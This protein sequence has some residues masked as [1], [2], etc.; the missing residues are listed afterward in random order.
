M[1]YLKNHSRLALGYFL[2]AAL[3]GLIL[4]SFYVLEI[5]ITFK[6]VVHAHSHIALL[7]WVYIALTTIIYKLYLEKL[8]LQKKY[9]YIFWFTQLTLV[10]MLCSFPFQGYAL[11]SIVFSTLFLIASY[12]FFIF[13]KKHISSENKEQNSYY[14]INTALWY[15]VISSIGPWALGGIMTTLGATS[16]WYRLAIYF[17]LHFQYNGWMILAL[18]GILL[19]I[20]EEQNIQVSKAVFKRFF[21]SI[22][23]GIITTFFLSTLF[24]KPPI[25]LYIL[26]GIG[27]VFQLYSLFLIINYLKQ[28]SEKISALVS[29]FQLSLLKTVGFFLLLKMILQLLTALPYFANLAVTILD[30][31][32]GYLHWTFLGVVTICLF[33]F[34]DYFRMIKIPKKAYY[35]YLSGFLLTE[36]LIFY[37]GFIIWQSLPLLHTYFKLLALASLLIVIAILYIFATSFFI[38][39]E[40]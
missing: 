40:K 19:Y 8:Q 20:L 38:K 7:G 31:T 6:F 17:Y 25:I 16:I 2:I 15:V 34:L 10:G 29:S 27:G 32:I 14:C 36:A 30:F 22:N 3:L 28:N 4:R 13:F 18:I 35:I 9:N 1:K 33:L 5:P 21:Y 24:T 37:K 26:G 12:W 11:F 23:I 39:K